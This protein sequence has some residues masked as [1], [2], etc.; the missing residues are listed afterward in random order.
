MRPLISTDLS[1]LI[2][3]LPFSRSRRTPSPFTDEEANS[4]G[5]ASLGKVSNEK[6]YN[7]PCA[8]PAQ[9]GQKYRHISQCQTDPPQPI[10]G[11]GQSGVQTHR[12]RIESYTPEMFDYITLEK[13]KPS[14]NKKAKLASEKRVKSPPIK[15][16]SQLLHSSAAPR[17]PKRKTS[18]ITTATPLLSDPPSLKPRPSSTDHKAPSSRRA[19]PLSMNPP[20]PNSKP[21]STTHKAP[22]SRAPPLSMNPP[23]PKPK[24][25]STAK[26]ALSS[27]TTKTLSTTLPHSKP[28]PPSTSTSLKPHQLTHPTTNPIAPSRKHAN[29]KPHRLSEEEM[30]ERY[31]RWYQ[32]R[33]SEIGRGFWGLE[34]VPPGN[35]GGGANTDGKGPVNITGPLSSAG[36]AAGGMD[37]KRVEQ[38]S[39]VEI[40]ETSKKKDKVR[41]NQ[42]GIGVAKSRISS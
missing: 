3:H 21:S 7:E 42:I 17:N 16:P 24:P 29:Q 39:P 41:G 15:S 23:P 22:I 38:Q 40:R 14:P 10:L 33:G 36:V 26:Q 12:S 2:N 11:R 30:N 32:G 20:P 19:P 8:N 4:N 6:P 34:I 27:P 35:S 28:R 31:A 5:L 37:G 13:P 25:S 1:T 18:P 9:Q